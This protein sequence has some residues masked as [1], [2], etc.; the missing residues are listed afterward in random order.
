MRTLV[1]W[2]YFIFYVLFSLISRLRVS[3]MK[4]M[5]KSKEA[6]A[7]AEA[8]VARCLRRVVKA[9]G[10]KVE[11]RGQDKI[12]EEAC[13]FIANHQSIVDILV[14][15]GYVNK[16]MGFVAKIETKK[17]PII[18][19]WMKWIHCVFIDRSNPREGLKAIN[20]G[21]E[22]VKKGHSMAIFPE[23]TRSKADKMGEFKKGSMRLA[24]KSHAPIVPVTIDG[25]YK[26][27]EGNNYKIK[28]TRVIVT[29]HDPVSIEDFGEREQGKLAEAIKET[30]ESS[31]PYGTNY[32]P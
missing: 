5:G 24:V 18:S 22:N 20:E 30:I 27:L 26:L 14:L 23:G 28:P 1:V 4:K 21:I 16:P 17:L 2:I 8:F 32:R 7:A 11:V 29:I 25:S 31:L 19:G 15:L 13:V 12:P 10:S 9:T 3:I 6:E